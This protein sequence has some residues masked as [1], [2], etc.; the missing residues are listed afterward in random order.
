MASPGLEGL[1]RSRSLLRATFAPLSPG[2]PLEGP[3]AAPRPRGHQ[4][5]A[6]WAGLP[7]VR[8]KAPPP[9]KPADQ[10][11]QHEICILSLGE[12][13]ALARSRWPGRGRR[14]GGESPVLSPYF[15]PLL[16]LLSEAPPIYLLADT[17]LTPDWPQKLNA[18]S[19]HF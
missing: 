8:P 18:P 17:L 2:R 14:G 16:A 9:R 10:P 7:R 6:A 19:L 13:E 12:G 5:P 11:T 1:A 15:L 4:R 3:A